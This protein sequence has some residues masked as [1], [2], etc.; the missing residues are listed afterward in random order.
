[1]MASPVARRD[2][3]S[4]RRRASRSLPNL[5]IQ[6]VD[7]SSGATVRL[8]DFSARSFAIESAD[9]MTKRR[10]REFEFPLGLGKIAFKGVPKRRARI[11]T[12]NGKA[13][14]LVA[15][16]FAWKTPLGREVIDQ[17]VRSVR[18]EVA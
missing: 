6:G 10:T 15:L 8:R 9:P 4:E 1:M 17:F 13:L 12:A 11:G 3:K 16:E 5:E 14:Y 18:G 7:L 2:Y